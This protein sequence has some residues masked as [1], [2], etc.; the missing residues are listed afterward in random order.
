MIAPFLR[1]PDLLQSQWYHNSVQAWL[2]AALTGVGTFVVLLVARRTA[3]SR[4]GAIAS[5]TTNNID[6]MFVEVIRETRKWVLF[7]TSIYVGALPLSLADARPY[8]H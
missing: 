4:L 8:L 5:R 2:T 1:V 3:V 7:A 6:D